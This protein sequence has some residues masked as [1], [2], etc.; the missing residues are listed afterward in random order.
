MA[1]SAPPTKAIATNV[2]AAAIA[3]VE[4]QHRSQAE[5]QRHQRH[6]P[7]WLLVAAIILTLLTVSIQGITEELSPGK[8]IQNVSINP[9]PPPRRPRCILRPR[10][11]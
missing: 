3:Q 10:G 6:Q 8:C 5:P 1:A 4:Q 11:I 2:A 9:N 7:Q